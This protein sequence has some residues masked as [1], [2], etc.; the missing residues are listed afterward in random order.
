[1]WLR[2]VVS[3]YDNEYL[4]SIKPGKFRER[5]CD[6]SF[7]REELFHGVRG[8]IITVPRKVRCLSELT[9][10]LVRLIHIYYAA[11]MLCPGHAMPH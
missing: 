4:G 8:N 7:S 6:I 5:F 1:M 3:D 2:M 10:F 9:V 11:P